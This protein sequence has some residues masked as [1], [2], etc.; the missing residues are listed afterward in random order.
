MEQRQEEDENISHEYVQGAGISKDKRH[1]KEAGVG[2]VCSRNS[3]KARV[4]ETE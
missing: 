3:K 4:A 1:S 2:L